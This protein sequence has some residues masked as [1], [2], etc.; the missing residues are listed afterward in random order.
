MTWWYRRCHTTLRSSGLLRASILA[1][2]STPTEEIREG[3]RYSASVRPAS[4]VA[5]RSSRGVR[6]YVYYV[7]CRAW[8]DDVGHFRVWDFGR[9]R[10]LRMS[11][12]C[13]YVL[14]NVFTI[15]CFTSRPRACSYADI[16]SLRV[17]FF[18]F[19]P[20]LKRR[21]VSLVRIRPPVVY[22][23]GS[24]NSHRIAIYRV[25]ETARCTTMLHT[26]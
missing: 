21:P 8:S 10:V 6:T 26:L 9:T 19:A 12:T 22:N 1:R 2:N 15:I 25:L 7:G 16:P 3:A 5:N 23:I 13:S 4:P 11:K 20:M 24:I 14:V 18:F 17:D